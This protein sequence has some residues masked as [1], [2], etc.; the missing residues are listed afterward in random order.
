MAGSRLVLPS[1]QPVQSTGL[2]YAGGQLFFYLSGTSTPTPTYSDSALTIPNANPIILDSAGDAGNVFLNPGLVYKVVL[3]DVNGNL[4][5]SFDPVNPF[6]P[7]TVSGAIWGGVSTGVANAQIVAASTFSAQPGQSIEFVAGFTNTGA[8]TLNAGTGQLQVYVPTLSGPMLLSGDEITTGNTYT[9]IYNPNLNSGAGGFQ[10]SGLIEPAVVITPGAG[11]SSEY[12]APSSTPGPELFADA[13]FWQGFGHGLTL[14]NDA[15]APNNVLDIA[16]GIAVSDNFTVFMKLSTAFTKTTGI[17]AAGTGNGALDTGTIAASTWYHVFI[18]EDIATLAVDVLFSAS[19][20]SPTLPTGF[21]VKKRRGS[22]KTDGSANILAFVQNG[23]YFW[24]A[25]VVFYNT[26]SASGPTLR[27][28]NIPLGVVTQPIVS[29]QMEQGS[30]G[31]TIV[32]LGAAANSA[33]A[34]AFLSTNVA[35]MVTASQANGPPSNL[36]SQIFLTVTNSGG[37]TSISLSCV[38]Y[39]DSL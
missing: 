35:N 22:F 19:A 24:M 6:A 30:A 18:I 4:V 37:L 10:I 28:L 29:G 21:T 34:S 7:G 27:T 12:G 38:G 2:P 14:S 11:L 1:Q 3:E 23:N 36:L 15:T 25:A 8:M 39:I 5:W 9:V 13:S 26:A 32:S 20:T 33:I 17:W 31:D 16:A